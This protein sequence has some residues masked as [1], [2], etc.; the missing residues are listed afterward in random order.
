MS[1]NPSEIASMLVDYEKDHNTN[2]NIEK[3]SEKIYEYT[4]GY[5][6]LVSKICKTIDE[7]LEKNFTIEAFDESIK[8][9]LYEQNTLFDDLIKNIEN[10]K[11]LRDIVEMIL[12]PNQDD[13]VDY[14][15][16]NLDISIGLMY[17]IFG[18]TIDNKL[19]IHN[20]IFEIRIYNYLIS[21][22]QTNKELNIN[23]PVRN[24]F[25]SSD[26]KTLLVEKIMI[27]FKEIMYG[28][29]RK[30]DTEFKEREGRLLFL[31]FI[32]PIINGRGSYYVE[33]ETRGNA[34]MDIV[35]KYGNHEYIIELKKWYGNNY[36]ENGKEQLISYLDSRNNNKG[37]I[38][39]FDFREEKQEIEEWVE[40][41]GKRIFI[42]NV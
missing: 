21:K 42:I 2:M 13:R 28:E 5:P 19:I 9:I 39:I 17:G 18:R 23:I 32:K 41:D 3:I 37:Y 20:K 34:R 36:L 24:Q 8:L 26:G 12:I 27:K 25:I 10:N 38:V 33:A 16:D 15:V 31:C 1:F 7:D 4:S 6:F 29:Y 35:I 40:V 14:N 22:R 30:R 11:S